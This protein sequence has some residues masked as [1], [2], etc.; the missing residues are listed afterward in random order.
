MRIAGS[1][2]RIGMGK[3]EIA[4]ALD[5]VNQRRC[6]PPLDTEEIE[7]LAD[8]AVRYPVEASAFPVVDLETGAVTQSCDR[9]TLIVN[10]GKDHEAAAEAEKIL[11]A[12]KGLLYR[13]GEDL[14]QVMPSD[15][16]V[17]A[18]SRVPLARILGEEIA[19]RG[20]K[21][22][23]GK[24]EEGYDE[25]PINPRTGLWTWCS[26]RAEFSY[27]SYGLSFA[28][29]RFDLTAQSSRV[30]VTMTPPPST[31]IPTAATCLLSLTNQPRPMP[32]RRWTSWPISSPTTP[33]RSLPIGRWRWPV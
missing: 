23:T 3:E 1:L 15:G 14:V 19:W 22:R 20:L 27:P 5:A 8:S 4:E 32:G 10:M 9:P 21:R 28:F 12:K 26:R 30:Q 16:S 31:S 6:S 33:S 11:V 7:K 13:R 29:R 25:I 24:G 2:R 18:M 17:L